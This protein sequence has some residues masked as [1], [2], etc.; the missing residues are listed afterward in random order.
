LLFKPEHIELI[1]QGKKWQTR[2]R[3]KK[4]RAREGAVHKLQTE[5]FGKTVGHI[6]IL[7]VWKEPLTYVDC[8]AEG[9]KS[10][11]DF[12]GIWKRIHKKWTYNEVVTVVEFVYV[13][14]PTAH[15]IKSTNKGASIA[16]MAYLFDQPLR[17]EF[18]RKYFE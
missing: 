8:K 9:Y 4:N 10:R 1:K 3:W 11:S 13:D 18:V 7:K 12:K 2:R 15:R 17:Q 6:L 14:A 5:L 16:R